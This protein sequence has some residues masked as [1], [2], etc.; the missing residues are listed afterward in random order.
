MRQVPRRKVIRS[1]QKRG[2]VIKNFNKSGT[3]GGGKNDQGNWTKLHPKRGD[4]GAV[5]RESKN[6]LQNGIFGRTG[7]YDDRRKGR[8]RRPSQQVK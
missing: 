8:V 3:R 4:P 1:G 7:K 6:R 2:K 5:V